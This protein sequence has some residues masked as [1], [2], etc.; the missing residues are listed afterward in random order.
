[1]TVDTERLEQEGIAWTE[2]SEKSKLKEII[3][4]V[5]M[6][7]FKSLLNL[8]QKKEYREFQL[9]IW[10][11][12]KKADGKLW[13]VTLERL[14]QFIALENTSGQMFH[15]FMRS[16]KTKLAIEWTKVSEKSKLREIISVLSK[17]TWDI[18]VDLL[19]SLIMNERYQ[20]FQET[21]WM[22][23]NECDGKLWQATLARLKKYMDKIIQTPWKIKLERSKDSMWKYRVY[24]Y[25]IKKWGQPQH[26]RRECIRQL[27]CVID[28]IKIVDIDWKEYPENKN[29]KANDKVF[30]KLPIIES[31]EKMSRDTREK[32]KIQEDYINLQENE[33]KKAIEK[34]NQQHPMS[35]DVEFSFAFPVDHYDDIEK[36]LYA[37]TKNQN[38]DPKKFEVVILLNSPNKRVPIDVNT[39]KKI[40]DFRK[41]YP[42]YNICLFEHTFNF[43]LKKDKDWNEKYDVKY[44]TFYK[45]LWDTIIYR[46]LQRKNIKWMD[47]RKIRNLIMKTWWAD[48]TDKNPKYLS[49]QLE[50]YSKAHNWKELVR[51]MSD[52]RLP[53]N[54]CENYPLIEI[55]EFFQRNFDTIYA[56]WAQN[57]DVW[58]WTYKAWMYCDV[59]GIRKGMTQ[60]EDKNFWKRIRKHIKDI[61]VDCCID[62]SPI[63]AAVDW[64][65]DRWLRAMVQNWD[66]Y[67][68]RY[69]DIAWNIECKKHNWNDIAMRHKWEKK[70][71]VL[72]L[73]KLN[74]EKNLWAYYRQ[75]INMIFTK[76]RGCS[77]YEKYLKWKWKYASWEDRARWIATNV[78]DPIMGEVFSMSNFMW[79]NKSDY[80]L[81][82]GSNPIVK[83]DRVK[84]WS[85]KVQFSDAALSKIKTIHQQKIKNWYYDY[86]K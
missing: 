1:M 67:C 23:K 79:L 44:G 55:L 34:F 9:K 62:Y 30:I 35:K 28:W 70:F 4:L 65:C 68:D 5:K 76:R 54:I 61:R 36:T 64:S 48:S 81:I 13:P 77:Q 45:L 6:K 10:I 17:E 8:I 84:E 75:C 57:R 63:V 78:V 21:I 32:I 33:D 12:W 11:E 22:G 20:K 37:I 27:W 83:D 66:A 16:K 29:F 52:S 50:E 38:I 73:T 14:Q 3:K 58:V 19:Y 46:N 39:R 25:I 59:G 43:G 7:G 15:T 26:I 82:L 86:R 31:F 56:W 53:K 42:E 49:K 51:L 85:V 74:L 47:M 69:N 71:L 60:Q 41:K 18:E 40:L 24:S 80:K 72:E 2:T